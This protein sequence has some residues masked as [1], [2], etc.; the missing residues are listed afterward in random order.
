MSDTIAVKYVGP[1]ARPIKIHGIRGGYVRRAD[2]PF[3]KVV[4]RGRRRPGQDA[5]DE[6]QRTIDVPDQVDVDAELAHRLCLQDCWDYVDDPDD[7][8]ASPDE[9]PD[10]NVDEILGWVGDDHD[11]ARAALAAEQVKD[12][13]RKGV[14]GRCEQLLE[15]VPATASRPTSP[16]GD[17]DAAGDDQEA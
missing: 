11:R 13:P 10:G 17:G 6:L 14:T 15:R 4:V 2:S 12:K 16:A 1:S 7:R 8:P 3:D 5:G 9:V